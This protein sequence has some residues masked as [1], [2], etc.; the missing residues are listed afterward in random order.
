M[1]RRNERIMNFFNYPWWWLY[2][3]LW[4]LQSLIDMASSLLPTQAHTTC[5]RE[6]KSVSICRHQ[7][8]HKDPDDSEKEARGTGT[9]KT[10]M[11]QR[12][13]LQITRGAY[14][15]HH[16][17]FQAIHDPKPSS[18]SQFQTRGVSGS[19]IS[20]NS[21]HSFIVYVSI[22]NWTWNGYETWRFPL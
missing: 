12:V 20:N 15:S 2:L 11:N 19:I 18:S 3:Q 21:N 4:T 5:C 10:L 22:F 8:K 6:W 17:S 14:W 7:R 13:S 16:H 9:R 1:A